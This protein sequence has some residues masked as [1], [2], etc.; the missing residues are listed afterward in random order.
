MVA[1][2]YTIALN[3]L[4]RALKSIEEN[5]YIV[6]PIVACLMRLC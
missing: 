4:K 1:W 2:T 6:M 5:A 3:R